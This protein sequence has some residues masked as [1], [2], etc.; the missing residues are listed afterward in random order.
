[1][2]ILQDVAS[3]TGGEVSALQ[4]DALADAAQVYRLR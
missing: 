3:L 4:K 1:M 2:T